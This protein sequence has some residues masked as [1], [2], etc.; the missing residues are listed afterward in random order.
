MPDLYEP[1]IRALLSKTKDEWGDPA[2]NRANL[3]PYGIN[4]FDKYLYGIDIVNGE[5]ILVMGREKRRKTTFAINVIINYMTTDTLEE[6]PVTVIDTLESGMPPSR[7]RDQLLS[8][9]ASRWLMKE[10][11]FAKGQCN[12]CGAD[13]CRQLT[14][15]PEYLRYN[16]RTPAQKLAIEYAMDTMVSWPLFLFGASYTQGSTRD[17]ATS[18]KGGGN[19][20][21][22]WHYKWAQKH[23]LL[24]PLTLQASRWD[25]LIKEFGARIFISDHI[26]QYSFANEPS[27]YEKQLRAVGAISDFVASQNIAAIVLSQ[28]SLTS[29]RESRTGQGR[30]GALGGSK[31]AQEAN[32]AL[33]THY[34]PDFGGVMSISIEESRKSGTFHVV[35]RLEDRSGAFYGPSEVRWKRI[36]LRIESERKDD[37]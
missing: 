19:M 28:V 16:P 6:K 31:L 32:V 12:E 24:D 14:L 9:L 15:T 30:I 8:N 1:D 3:I 29:V 5:L 10:G 23:N 22:T 36:D 13:R 2:V 11:H 21:E 35:Q 25:F 37:G 26:Q 18:V 20:L 27:D 7:Y 17:L 33:S 34:D 4:V